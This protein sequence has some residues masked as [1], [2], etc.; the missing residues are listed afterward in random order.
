MH[1]NLCTA[2]MWSAIA[3][4]SLVQGQ[5][6]VSTDECAWYD[7]TLQN[8]FPKGINQTNKDV[9]DASVIIN[10]P[11]APRAG[12]VFANNYA[13]TT[14]NGSETG[15]THV[16]GWLRELTLGFKKG[17]SILKKSVALDSIT[18]SNVE[19]DSLYE[20]ID[21]ASLTHNA[22]DGL[23]RWGDH[24]NSSISWGTNNHARDLMCLF[25][26]KDGHDNG[27]IAFGNDMTQWTDTSSVLLCGGSWIED[28]GAGIFRRSLR[29]SWN[30]SYDSIGFRMAIYPS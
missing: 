19:D 21:A 2:F 9:N 22:V 18:A 20:S 14:H 3:C 4:L 10:T 27:N 13:K 15:I 12:S 11:M 26:K 30:D 5:Y 16:N 7:S 29:N 17:P 24:N 1:A 6:A 8:N 23:Y 25:P 28:K